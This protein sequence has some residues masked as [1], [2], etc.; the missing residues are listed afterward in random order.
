MRLTLGIMFAAFFVTH[1]G[2]A[3]LNIQGSIASVDRGEGYQPA[4]ADSPVKPGDRVRVRNGC[5][6]IVYGGGYVNKIC[7]GQTAVV[8]S[9]YTPA[10]GLSLKDTPAPLPVESSSNDDL[11][12]AG[13]IVGTGIGTGIAIGVQPAS[14]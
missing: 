5:A 6:R 14:P 3:V 8:L 10:Q 2:A 11:L 4:V 12:M 1:C 13:L 9:D 7:A